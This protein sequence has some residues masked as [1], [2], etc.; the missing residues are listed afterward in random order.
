MI[1]FSAFQTVQFVSSLIYSCGIHLSNPV[2]VKMLMNCR[3]LFALFLLATLNTRVFEVGG[4]LPGSQGADRVEAVVDNID[5]SYN[6]AT[7]LMTRNKH[8]Y[9]QRNSLFMHK[10]TK[11]EHY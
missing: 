8:K 11:Q 3:C 5:T 10:D 2:T 7:L 4:S 6:E 9:T 1:L